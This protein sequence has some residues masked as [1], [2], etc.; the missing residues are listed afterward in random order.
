MSTVV[1]NGTQRLRFPI[2]KL[3]HFC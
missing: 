1:G 3:S 2:K